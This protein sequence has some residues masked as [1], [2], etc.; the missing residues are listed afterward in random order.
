MLKWVEEEVDRVKGMFEEKERR[1]TADAQAALRDC[2]A[3]K[4]SQQTSAAAQR[5]AEN[6]LGT[7]AEQLQVLPMLT[8]CLP[9]LCCFFL[10][11]SDCADTCPLPCV[12]PS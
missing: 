8:R 6:Q 3:A 5:E 11:C 2:K 7:V 10:C 12:I 4:A 9:F 1:L